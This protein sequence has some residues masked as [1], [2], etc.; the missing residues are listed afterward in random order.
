[1]N[2]GALGGTFDP[3]HLGH[4]VIA[5][6]VRAHLKLDKVLFVPSGHPWLKEDRL[7]TPAEHRLAMLRLAL[8]SNPHFE[9]ST[10]DI[11]RKGPS[12]T[13]DTLDDLKRK[14]GTGANLFFIMG[15]DSL[16]DMPLWKEPGRIVQQ[17]KLVAVRRPGYAR[18]DIDGLDRIVPGISKNLLFVDI[19]LLSVSSREIR[20]R[21]AAG[22]SIKYLVPEAVEQYIAANGL[23]K[24]V[25]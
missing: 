10:A 21:A 5:E 16:R 15:M 19:T 7:V 12:Y 25:A 24:P 3:V 1:M 13:V 22:I 9:I 20:R 18:P 11:D 14:L 6:E 8:E 4:L 2:I 17:C 23:Y